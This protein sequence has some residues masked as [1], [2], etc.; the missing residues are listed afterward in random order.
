MEFARSAIA[1]V[2]LITLFAAATYVTPLLSRTAAG[3]LLHTSCGVAKDFNDRS[4][5]DRT[6]IDQP[7]HG[8]NGIAAICRTACVNS[9]G[10]GCCG[11]MTV[12]A[13]AG[14]SAALHSASHAVADAGSDLDGFEPPIPEE[15]PQ[16]SA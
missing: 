11:S 12:A 2:V 9:T 8:D 4:T 1:V 6:S 14:I 15:P 16:Q 10:P 3:G 7:D 5:V 13:S